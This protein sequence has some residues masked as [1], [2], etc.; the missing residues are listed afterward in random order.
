MK[1]II[2]T[3]ASVQIGSG[4]VMRC[5]TAAKKLRA[6][7]CNVSFWMEPLEGNLIDYVAAQ[8][9]DNV[10]Q[11]E[12]ADLYIVDHYG[13]SIEW[14]RSIRPFTKKLVVID[15]L[16]RAHDCDLLL[17]QNVVPNYETRYND[18][19]PENCMKLLGPKFLMIRDEFIEA[20]Q[21]MKKRND[22]VENLLVFMGGTDPTNETM[23][24]L[25]ALK[26]CSFKC[27][28]VVVGNGNPVKDEIETVC[29]EHG[30]VFH[31]QINYMARLMCEA[32]FAIG[33]G[34]S[35]LWERCYVGLPSSSTIVADN[36]RETTTLAGE[37][38]VTVNLGWHEQVTVETYR[39]LLETLDVGEMSE[40]GLQLTATERPNAWLHEMLELI[41]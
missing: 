5:L 31:C 19:V 24:I 37:L 10:Q 30:Y 14:E 20:G 22:D 25:H 28:N 4:H 17:D 21:Q 7:G 26:G 23:K 34:G 40:K 36:Q 41:K 2:R 38:G 18:K 27:V 12:Q 15:D 32:D 8:G 33:A 9:F 39:Q 16:A 1:V 6:G 3:D 11:A 13:L 35:T 29:Q